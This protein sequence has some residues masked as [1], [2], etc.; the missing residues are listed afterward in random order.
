MDE[1]FLAR[2]GHLATGIRGTAQPGIQRAREAPRKGDFTGSLGHYGF[3]LQ[4]L[5]KGVA[6][7]FTFSFQLYKCNQQ[8]E[9]CSVSNAR[10]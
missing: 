7:A 5:V 4:R 10:H 6:V 8:H 1:R 2:V 9:T 3:V